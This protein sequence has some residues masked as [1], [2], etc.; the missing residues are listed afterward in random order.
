[1]EAFPPG[2]VAVDALPERLPINPPEE[3]TVDVNED[4]PVLVFIVNWGTL[5]VPRDIELLPNI[6]LALLPLAFYLYSF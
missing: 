6:N 4:A 2:L 3:V 1:M 5:V